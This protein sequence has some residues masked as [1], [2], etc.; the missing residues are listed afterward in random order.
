[1]PRILIDEIMPILSAS[2]PRLRVISCDDA[3]EVT[4]DAVAGAAAML[5]SAERS[6]KP[7]RGRSVAHYCLQRAK[8]GRRSTSANRTDVLAPSTILDGHSVVTSLDTP[9]MFRA[10]PSRGHGCGVVT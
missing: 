10:A 9:M 3:E 5:D 7:L 4:A 8:V 2:I 6:G 1:M